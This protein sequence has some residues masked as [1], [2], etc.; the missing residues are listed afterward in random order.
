MSFVSRKS[1]DKFSFSVK[2]EYRFVHTDESK[3]FLKNLINTSKKKEAFLS[4]GTILYRA[5]R[6]YD[7]KVEYYNDGETLINIIVL[8]YNPSRM[9]PDPEKIGNGRANAKGIP[10]L[11]LS[12]DENTAIAEV[13]PWLNEKVSVAEFKILKNIRILDFS[14]IESNQKIYFKEP[15]D[16]KIIENEVWAS[17][18]RAFSIP[19]NQE[20]QDKDY[21]PTQIISELFKSQGYDGIKYK[22]LLS[23]GNN[24][25]I[26]N[27][28]D[29]GPV[30]GA[31]FEVKSLDY[32]SKQCSNPAS[33]SIGTDERKYNRIVSFKTINKKE[34]S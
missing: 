6:G 32:F 14:N 18:N 33:Y 13:R 4:E 5:Q 7:E 29:A 20:E 34:K 8:P 22:S 24:Y 3:E 17:V 28:S 27:I 9:I 25:A 11:Y 10:C 23:P 1:F 15:T 31:V 2:K 26:Y 19:V 30:K 16:Q 21:I 12:D